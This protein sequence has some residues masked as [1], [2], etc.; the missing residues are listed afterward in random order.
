MKKILDPNSVAVIGATDTEG[1]IG[2]ILLK[3]ISR[4]N[5]IEIYP[6]NPKHEEIGGLKAYA[7]VLDIEKEIDLA[8][9]AVP[10]KFV[11]QA[12][13]DCALKSIPI[14]DIVIIS[15]GFSEGDE[16]GIKREEELKS[17]AKEHE[18]KIVGPNCLG[19]VN[20]T[21]NFNGS[22]AGAEISKG[23]VG[24]VMQ[25]G[26]LT[27]ALFDMA[28]DGSFGFSLVTTLGNKAIVNENDLLDYYLEDENTKI[29]ALY[30]E[31]IANGR[32]FTKKLKVA[33][34]IKPV[35]VLK[36]GVSKKAQ[37]AI[38]SHTGAMAGDAAVTKEAIESNGGIY[39]KNLQEFA[40][41]ISLLN[42]S[43]P[44]KNKK[45]VIV[46]NA[47]GPGV[48]ATDIIESD[49]MLEMFEFSEDDKKRIKEN[50]PTESSAKNPIDV[51]GD[52]MEDRYFSTLEILKTV[53][54]IGAILVIVTPQSQTPI[55]KIAEVIFKM[56]K[57]AEIPIVPVFIG[58]LSSERAEKYL[59]TKGLS[60]FRFAI[61]AV[62]ALERA[63]E[64]SR[65]KSDNKNEFLIADGNSTEIQEETEIIGKLVA[66]NRKVFYYD[67]A[68]ELGNSF[69]LNIL[70]ASYLKENA[71]EYEGGYPAVLKLDSPKVLHKN[72]K[73]ALYLNIKDEQELEICRREIE[74]FFPNG[75]ILVQPMIAQGLEVIIGIKE[76]KDFG[77]VLMVGLGG[78]MTE[79]FDT[80]LLW[81]LPVAEDMIRQKIETSLLGKVLKKQ[82]IDIEVLVS[83]TKKVANLSMSNL[84]IKELDINPIML[85]PDHDPMIVDIKVLL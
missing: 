33:T 63:W 58:G 31:D 81:L 47:G 72:S 29:I 52:A 42:S 73:D 14:K 9:I 38:Q 85:Y 60:N 17:F 23:N 7:S 19:V 57:L 74:N 56:N 37:I 8:I 36:A 26:A 32:E 20:T 77:H 68:T 66:E 39:C 27:T 30:L 61:S 71:T 75:R 80:K 69:G 21:A 15:A 4:N 35:I 12:V 10:A 76:N 64:F 67:E 16:E 54:G 25:S 83:A 6:I 50:L 79:L 18:L 43:A 53:E 11:N 59:A 51:L 78:I 40:G 34:K 3:N 48:V 82:K 46:T 55:E 49:S 41:V 2:N 28:A 22:F 5:Q 45:V 1:K 13:R 24:L 44:P 65:A 70:N 84:K 62:R